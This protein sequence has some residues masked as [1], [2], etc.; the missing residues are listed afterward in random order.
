MERIGIFKQIVSNPC[1]Y[2]RNWK[3]KTRGK[4]IGNFC[5]YTPEELITAAGALPFRILGSGATISK[6]NA[7]LQAYSCSLVRGA[8]EDSLEGRL[9]FLDGTVFPHT[10]D[11]IQR[12]SDIWRMNTNYA[13]HADLIMPVKLDTES[14]EQYMI[15]V[16]RKFRKDLETGFGIRITDE[17]LKKAIQTSN[18]VRASLAK[19]YEI[20]KNSPEKLKSSELHT[21]FKASMVM[22]RNQLADALRELITFLEDEKIAETPNA[23][24]IVLT[25][26]LCSMPDIYDVIESSNGAVVWDDFCTGS[27]YFEGQINEEGDLEKNIASR[28]IS[29][30]VC[31]AKHSGIYA[32]GNYLLDKVRENH[33]DGV[34]FVFLKFCDPHSF[35]YPY[36]KEMLEKEGI[37]SMLFEIEEQTS[38]GGQLQTRCE[39]FMEML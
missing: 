32:R 10:C 12:L 17:M 39:A 1:E 23:K 29:R 19:L 7:F 34:I 24:R 6:A 30:I 37:P 3:E 15:S 31:P 27:R 35:D 4:V 33:A 11:S 21:V 9:N 18:Q 13:F 20:R 16:I 38:S 5:S 36:M 25:G 8:L 14:A 2:A 28:Y 22:D 26:G